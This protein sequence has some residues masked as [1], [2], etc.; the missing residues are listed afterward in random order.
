MQNQNLDKELVAWDSWCEVHDSGGFDQFAQERGLD[1]QTRRELKRILKIGDNIWNYVEGNNQEKVD[2]F[3]KELLTRE[4][5]NRFEFSSELGAGGMGTVWLAEQTSPI[6]RKVAV[7]LI[8]N[9]L[10]SVSMRKRFAFEQQ[11]LASLSHPNIATVHEAGETENGRSYFV[12]EYIPGEKIT[13]YCNRNKLDLRTRLE[14]FL[15]VCDGIQHAHR[16]GLIHRDIKPGNV[17]V[18]EENGVPVAKLIGFG[19]AK[20]TANL[21]AQQT[22]TRTNAVIGSPVWMSPEQARV[23]D[24]GEKV[25]VDTRTDV[26]SLGVI[27]Y[28]LLTNSTPIPAEFIRSSPPAKVFDA[29]RNQIPAYPSRR[30]GEQQ[31]DSK[32]WIES[33]SESSYSSW[34][35]SLKNDLDWVVMKAIE[36]EASRRYGTVNELVSDISSFIKGD[37]VTARPPSGLYQFKKMVGRNQVLTASIAGVVLTLLAAT[38][39]STWYAIKATRSQ[40]L[41]ELRLESS[42]QLVDAISG[43]FH[44]FSFDDAS[45]E[46]T[47]LKS[48]LLKEVASRI[49]AALAAAPKN[50][51]PEELARREYA[52]RTTFIEAL[53]HASLNEDAVFEL[54]K[55]IDILSPL[56]EPHEQMLLKSQ[57]ELSGVLLKTGESERASEIAQ[58][59]LAI[60]RNFYNSTNTLRL[61]CER[62]WVAVSSEKR[63]LEKNLEILRRVVKDATEVGSDDSHDICIRTMDQVAGLYHQAAKFDL[64]IEWY[65]KARKFAREKFPDS[66]GTIERD[67]KYMQEVLMHNSQGVD[68]NELKDFLPTL[69]N[70]LGKSHP[71]TLEYQAR[72]GCSL[73]VVKSSP[74]EGLS[75][76]R[77]AL[78]VSAKKLGVGHRITCLAR[79]S[80]IRS[81][82]FSQRY[83]E[84]HDACETHLKDLE[85]Y[86]IPKDHASAS[87]VYA[88]SLLRLGDFERSL[89][90]AEKSNHRSVAV[91]ALIQLKR[92]SEATDIL[93][94]LI[95]AKPESSAELNALMSPLMQ[96][97]RLYYTQGKLDKSIESMKK[98]QTVALKVHP[99]THVQNLQAL[100]L[101][102]NFHTHSGKLE[103]SN[104]YGRQ[105]LSTIKT[106]KGG[107]D[108]HTATFFSG[109]IEGL[110]VC[111]LELGNYEDVDHYASIYSELNVTRP[112]VPSLEN[113]L[114]EISIE[115]KIRQKKYE[116]AELEALDWLSKLQKRE[117]LEGKQRFIVDGRSK[118]YPLLINAY[119]ALEKN[120]KV[121]EYELKAKNFKQ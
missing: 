82:Y 116:A 78:Q 16:K 104:E 44:V 22:F 59:T 53:I 103:E 18:M 49:E 79:L 73:A 30:L 35:G 96:M 110:S 111:S 119:R 31:N 40:K 15:Q 21:F 43:G 38:S 51:P 76:I 2:A 100:S 63:S 98:F 37:S 65:D 77:E 91:S 25:Q 13:D 50:L 67:F 81:L 4:L 112:G 9:D 120:D 69:R 90:V 55:L 58:K 105:L 29:I 56:V 94:T 27:L 89:E 109:C 80:L 92:F 11:A 6:R 115:S 83:Q 107:F 54:D 48:L 84:A 14:L 88:R 3:T 71:R 57:L 20:D 106:L 32:S 68:S 26:Y 87:W 86:S 45:V 72:Y 61:D 99:P 52:W 60:V 34:V 8:R 74:D 75:L 121:K 64:S 47:R 118:A 114:K 23:F 7:K 101:L 41:A 108:F 113:R 42:D 24:D 95:D 39:V 62:H 36:K 93:D 97:S 19:L 102:Q 70:K 85:K 28:Q 12:M 46:S 117:D 66:V 5:G 10:V 33:S 1:E 17:I